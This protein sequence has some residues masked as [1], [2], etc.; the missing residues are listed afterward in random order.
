[1]ELISWNS[2]KIYLRDLEK[3][4]GVVI[5]ETIFV[6]TTDGEVPVYQDVISKYGG[7]ARNS[8]VVIKPSVSAS[9]KETHRIPDPSSEAYDPTETQS[10]WAQVYTYTRSLSPTVKIMIQAFE[11]SIKNGEYSII[12]LGGKYSHTILKRPIATDFRAIEEYGA[13]IGELDDSKVPKK[14]K[15][16]GRKVIEYVRRRFGYGDDWKL[17]Y[18]R[19]DGVVRDDGGFVVIEA[20]M[21]EPYVYLNVEGAKRGLERLC[22]VLGG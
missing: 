20:E 1:M 19:L 5:P 8:S 4:L 15:E 11:P 21:L 3:D 18:L 7:A 22:E 16:I 2:N 9:A 10:S 14:G 13:R 12:F 6:D 17:G